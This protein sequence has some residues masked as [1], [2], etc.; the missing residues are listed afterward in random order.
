MQPTTARPRRTHVFGA[1]LLPAFLLRPFYRTLGSRLAAGGEVSYHAMPGGGL[2]RTDAIVEW[3]L[4]LLDD[5]RGRGEQVRLA[6][7][8]LGG[9]VAWALAHEI[10]EAV[11]TVELWG[12]PLRGTGLAAFFRN[13]GV[14]EA[15]FL[16]P[17]SRWLARYDTPLCGP[18]VRSVYTAC[19]LFV[20]PPRDSCFVEG[21]GAENHYLVP[22][23]LRG[24]ERRR[25][26]H[27][28]L[29]WADHV[30]LPKHPRVAAL[31]AA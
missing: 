19:D 4:P 22:T 9:V 11:E 2:G 12:A 31:T 26:E 5:A 21:D 17:G 10:P 28:H 20:M 27:V 3:F 24:P 23:P 15:R 29:A 1:T 14:A 16:S 18:R 25:H 13:V 6:G 8:S 7:H 30:L